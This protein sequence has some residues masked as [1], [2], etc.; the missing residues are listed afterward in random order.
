MILTKNQAHDV[1][2][3]KGN[4]SGFEHSCA[5]QCPVAVT[6]DNNGL[7]RGFLI[8]PTV[9]KTRDRPPLEIYPKT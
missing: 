5:C 6:S 8:V 1:K 4:S 7:T 2:Q 3:Y 9:N